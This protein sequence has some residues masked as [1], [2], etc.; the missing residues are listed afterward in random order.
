MTFKLIHRYKKRGLS[1]KETARLLSIGKTS[2]SYCRRN[3]TLK[4]Y[5]KFNLKRNRLQRARTKGWLRYV[6]RFIIN[7]FIK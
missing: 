6:P 1:I 5:Q 4:E 7:K 3:K 2:V